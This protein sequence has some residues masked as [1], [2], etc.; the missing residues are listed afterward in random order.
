MRV[1]LLTLMAGPDGVFNVGQTIDI[2]VEQALQIINSGCAVACDTPRKEISIE[3]AT[4]QPPEN[5]TVEHK[6]KKRSRA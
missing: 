2:P 3:T 5:E 4:I 1:K 6:H